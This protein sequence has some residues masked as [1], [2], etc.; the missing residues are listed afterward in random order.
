MVISLDQVAEHMRNVG[1]QLVPYNFPQADPKLEN[2]LFILKT[3]EMFVDGYWVM[4]HYNKADYKTYFVETFQVFGKKTP[5]LSFSLVVKLAK[6]F[7]GGHH[8][9]LSEILKDNRKIYCWTVA[10]DYDGR[11]MVPPQKE[12]QVCTFEGFQYAYVDPRHTNF[13]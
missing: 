1:E 2:D 8:L 13:Y 6:K 12:T 11:P 10:V 3:R 4:L 5:F 9:A 7:L